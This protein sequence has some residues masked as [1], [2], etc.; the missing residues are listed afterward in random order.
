MPSCVGSMVVTMS[1]GSR[2]VSRGEWDESGLRLMVG[3]ILLT[4]YCGSSLVAVIHSGRAGCISDQTI[5]AGSG[6][7]ILELLYMSD[8][9]VM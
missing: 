2:S 4:I 9:R 8:H 7:M 3:S 6:D 5:G 1:W